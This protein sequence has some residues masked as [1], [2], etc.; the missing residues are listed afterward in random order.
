M[1][2]ASR[3]GEQCQREVCTAE[4]FARPACYATLSSAEMLFY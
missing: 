3:H 4:E 2:D 1:E